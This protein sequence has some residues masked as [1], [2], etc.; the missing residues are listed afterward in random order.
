MAE[1]WQEVARTAA[2]TQANSQAL[3]MLAWTEKHRRLLAEGVPFDLTGHRYLAGVYQDASREL[4][5]MKSG[6]GGASEYC[7]SR[8]L[9]SCDVRAM[10]V[11]YLLP[12][13]SD[14]SDFSQMRIGT[15]LEASDYLAGIVVPGREEK[16]RGGDRV[17][18]KR[19]RDRWLVLRGAQVRAGQAADGGPRAGASR[20]KSVPVDLVIYDEFDEMPAGVEALAVK[21]L[22]HSAHK[23]QVW[24]STPTYP[25]AGIHAKYLLSDQRRWEVRCAGCRTWQP[26]TL[27][28]VV[29]ESDDLGRPVAWHGQAEGR[30]FC[31]CEKCGKE[32]DRLADG[33]WVAQNPGAPITGYTFNKLATAQ[34]DPLAVVMALQTTDE[35]KRQEA[36]NQDLALPYKPRGGGLDMAALDAC[37]RDYAHGAVANEGTVMGIDVGRVLHVVIRGPESGDTGERAQRWAGEVLS[38]EEAARLARQYNV[39][40]VVCDALPET[41]KAREFQDMLPARTV[42]LAYYSDGGKAAEPAAWKD[43][44]GPDGWRGTVTLD[45]TRLLDETIDRFLLQSNTLPGHIRA[46]QRYYD[47]LQ[48]PVRVL[49]RRPDGIDVARYVETGPDHFAHA[50]AYAT[51]ASMAAGPVRKA[52][53]WGRR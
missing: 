33:R 30:A 13:I 39:Q 19:I 47:Q 50:E 18:L 45:R 41:R 28:R 22:G 24:V 25:G 34:N 31:A 43:E 15:A 21:R 12:T 27:E 14:I 53:T 3:S 16:K 37:R 17:Q 49:Q 46:V 9:W 1:A 5:I 35:S 10:N 52:G 38:F 48:A 11:L 42:W 20:L 2:R 32:L 40:R 23:E 7:I 51:A 26:L 6:Q 44:R 36:Y 8:A 4:V 29:I